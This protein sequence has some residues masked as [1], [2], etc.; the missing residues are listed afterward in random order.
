M[1]YTPLLFNAMLTKVGKVPSLGNKMRI[2][3]EIVG[4]GSG[5]YLAM[6]LNCSIYPQIVPIDVSKLEP[7]I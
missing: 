3:T 4:V 1:F 7:E 6:G 2:L 5:L